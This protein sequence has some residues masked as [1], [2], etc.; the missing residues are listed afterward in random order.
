MDNEWSYIDFK[1]L[2]E[3]ILIGNTS[4]QEPI[5]INNLN[6]SQTNNIS[7][8]THLLKYDNIT[9]DNLL[10][11]IFKIYEHFTSK[12]EGLKKNKAVFEMMKRVN[13]EW[14]LNDSLSLST[15]FNKTFFNS[16][17]K[18]KSEYGDLCVN[19]QEAILE[20]EK[21]KKHPLE[22]LLHGEDMYERE[23]KGSNILCNRMLEKL[24]NNMVETEKLLVF[25]K[26]FNIPLYIDLSIKHRPLY[27]QL[28]QGDNNIPINIHRIFSNFV[29]I[30]NL[31]FKQIIQ[32]H[33]S[34]KD[35]ISDVEGKKND[36]ND[37]LANIQIIATMKNEGN[38][39]E[40][41]DRIV[42][43]VGDQ[44]L[45]KDD[46]IVKII[47][48]NENVPED[49][50]PIIYIQFEDGKVRDVLLKDL[51]EIEEEDFLE[52][53]EEEDGEIDNVTSENARNISQKLIHS[54]FN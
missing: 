51:T 13:N 24:K 9:K 49:E 36:V 16:L 48:I 19:C 22:G 37:R 30:H 25:F 43:N 31:L 41:E 28:T 2:M 50:E 20:S 52:D 27:Y 8:L 34:L 17:N 38:E 26:G 33:K 44:V 35:I 53:E 6:N 29:H 12:I 10:E 7:F 4:V 15:P 5:T 3:S 14:Y 46:D 42:F 23:L 45:Y 18:I 47:D 39:D 54:F 21:R 32:H 1:K 11:N 40:E